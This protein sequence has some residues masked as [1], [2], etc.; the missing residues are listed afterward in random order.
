MFLYPI[1]I[2]LPAHLGG[3]RFFYHAFAFFKVEDEEDCGITVEYG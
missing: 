3:G 1:R 2:F